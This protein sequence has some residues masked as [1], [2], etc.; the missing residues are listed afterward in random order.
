MAAET[1]L[2]WFHIE[3]EQRATFLSSARSASL[4]RSSGHYEFG[5]TVM[6]SLE[7]TLVELA[8]YVSDVGIYL[9]VTLFKRLFSQVDS[10][11]IT[12]ILRPL[13]RSGLRHCQATIDGVGEL[14]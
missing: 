11:G 4:L 13:M 8:D 2:E 6:F 3:I 7:H 5:D 12:A 9:N 1:G 10:E 14:L